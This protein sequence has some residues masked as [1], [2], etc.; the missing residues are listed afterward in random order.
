MGMIVDNGTLTDELVESLNRFA[1]VLLSEETLTSVLDLVVNL[2]EKTIAG[3]DGVSVTMILDGR[4]STA[5]HSH[6]WVARIDKLQYEAGDG[7]C[8]S[9]AE[10]KKIYRIDDVPT[11]DRW[12]E[13][14]RE[15]TDAGVKS[16]LSIPFIPLNEPIGALNVYSFTRAAFDDVREQV[17]NLLAQQAAI[18]L[19]NSK[20]FA[21]A[22][23]LNGQ[24]REALTSRDVIGQAKGIIMER[25]KVD[26]D[27]AF[28]ILKSTS[29][30]ANRKLR[31]I[32][33][34]VVNSVTA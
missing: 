18:V 8:L 17:A 20:A 23:E 29:Q 21:G 19:A 34:D 7:P 10:E 32:A 24:L 28:E 13:F 5:A 15:A 6:D 4:Y 9:A 14:C 11:E 16:M 3:A 12:S 31:D 1:T 30:R 26:A 25:E 22:E 27:R 2:T 33:Q